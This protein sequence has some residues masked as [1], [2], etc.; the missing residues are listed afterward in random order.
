[1]NHGE[2]QEHGERELSLIM[3]FS[4][5][6]V[7]TVVLLCYFAAL[8]FAP[9]IAP[10]DPLQ[11]SLTT[12]QP[13][14][15]AHWFGTDDL[16]RDV[17]SGV[18]HGARTSLLIGLTV[19]LISSLLGLLIGVSAGWSGGLADDLLMRLT[20][21]FLTPPRFFLALVIAAIFG[22]SFSTLILV[23]SLTFWPMT[24]R[25]LRAE[26]LTLR[27]RGFVEAARAIGATRSRILWREVL[28]HLL[29]L[30]VTSTAV[31]VGNVIL[32][33]AGLEFLGLGDQERITWGYLLHNGQHFMRD[34]WWMV[35][36]PL[37]AISV[38]LVTINLAGDEL[39]R[40][41][42]PQS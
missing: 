13:P 37:L 42:N 24:A 29:P 17:F 2:H 25:V 36:F 20:E 5:R 28:P 38:L 15:P 4:V 39:N 11:T 19:A 34:A 1:M 10:A 18:V 16:G 30:L 33:E 26:T 23:L 8:L 35:V 3:I 14:S 41:L 9:V 21:L 6:S 7:C 31:R 12:L 40:K 32:V 27:E 22:S